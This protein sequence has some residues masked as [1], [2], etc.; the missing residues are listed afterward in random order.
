MNNAFYGQDVTP[1]D[2]LIRKTV[3]NP[4]GAAIVAE[5]EAATK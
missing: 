5:V 2:I 4:N 3:V 1:T